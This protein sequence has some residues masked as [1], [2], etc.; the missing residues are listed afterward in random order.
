MKFE[1]VKEYNDYLITN[2]KEANII[3]YV[4]SINIQF[5]YIDISFINKLMKYVNCNEINIPHTM[6]VK[7]RVLK[8]NN[9]S[10]NIKALIR[11]SDF[12]EDRNF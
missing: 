12:K 7:Y 4:K 11:Q 9:L 3:D 1:T 5:Y 2:N 6:L 8:E 10:A